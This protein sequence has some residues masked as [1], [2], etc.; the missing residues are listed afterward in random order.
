MHCSITSTSRKSEPPR[1]PDQAEQALQDSNQW[2]R[3]DGVG[4]SPSAELTLAS[5]RKDYTH[6][7]RQLTFSTEE[8]R[9]AVTG[10]LDENPFIQQIQEQ[11]DL[12]IQ[13]IEELV[14]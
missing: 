11:S 10:T 9:D 6:P 7:F 4:S 1:G 14:G 13:K 8:E 5:R 2:A 12:F 3:L